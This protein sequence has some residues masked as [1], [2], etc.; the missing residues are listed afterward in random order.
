MALRPI[1]KAAV[2]KAYRQ[3]YGGPV[4]QGQLLAYFL[5]ITL[6][7]VLAMVLAG[8]LMIQIGGPQFES[9]APLVPLTA[10]AMSMPALYRTVNGV[11]NYPNKR[12]TF[13]LATVCAALV[14]IGV[15]LMLLSW[16]DIGI[17]AAPIGMLVAFAIPSTYMFLRSQLGEKPIEVPYLAMGQAILV[18]AGLGVAYHFAHPDGEWLQLPLIVLVMGIW[19]ASLFLLRIIPQYHWH[20]IRHIAVSAIRGSALQFDAG[21]G[22]ASLEPGERGALRAAVVERLPA[23]ALVPS[24]GGRGDGG[25]AEAILGE[26]ANSDESC[27][28]AR[29]VGLLRRAG[30]RG[31]VPVWGSSELDAGISLFL[32]SDRP[33]AVRSAKMRELLGVGASAHDL[34][35]LEDL[36][37]DLAKAPAEAWAPTPG[38][39]DGHPPGDPVA[40]KRA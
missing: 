4:A 29:L 33:L 36:R 9:A 28:G 24:L 32:F 5:L 19:I 26:A 2:F 15:V 39:P 34:R 30:E 21:M 18:A 11:A 10:A 22:L 35:T 17:Y 16:T 1:R 3:E 38:D 13:I 25:Q 31:G 27:E 12:R 37:D 23:E 14:Y 40:M 20:P 8:E 6:T 7:A